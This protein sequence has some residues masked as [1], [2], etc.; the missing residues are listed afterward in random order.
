MPWDAVRNEM[1]NEKGLSAD[2]TDRIWK[3][4][5]L[6]GISSSD[7][8]IQSILSSIEG[9]ADLIDQ[10][11]N[12]SELSAQPLAIEA[13]NDLELLF[14]YLGLLDITDKVFL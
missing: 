13:L 5:Q 6:H 9:N 4:V 2:V 3:Y 1:I 12:D 14:H 7:I 11:R 10:L 8:L